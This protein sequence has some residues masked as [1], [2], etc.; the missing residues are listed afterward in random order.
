M[1]CYIVTVYFQVLEK[2]FTQF[3]PIHEHVI[4]KGEEI[5][6]AMKP[7]TENEKLKQRLQEVDKRWSD[8]SEKINERRTKLQEVEPSASKYVESSEPFTTWLSESEGRL[9]ECEN[10][11]EDDESIARQLELLEVCLVLLDF[12]LNNSDKSLHFKHLS[13]RNFQ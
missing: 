7:G 6:Q 9:K 5:L 11:P 13:P 4:K 8:L 12:V 3:K 2:E 1:L 10:I